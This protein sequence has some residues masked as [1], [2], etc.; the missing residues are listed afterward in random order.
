[1]DMPTQFGSTKP[2]PHF[3]LRGWKERDPEQQNL[4][5][6]PEQKLVDVETPS[7]KE[8]MGDDEVP[9]K[10]WDAKG[11]PVPQFSAAGDPKPKKKK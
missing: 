11:D 10:D 2:R 9:E 3:E 5:A 6:A 4:L 8:Q 1:M 7:L